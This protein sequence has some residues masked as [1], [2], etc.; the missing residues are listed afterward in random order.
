MSTH[1]L[2]QIRAA[3]RQL[4]PGSVREAAERPVTI[5][6]FA[7][8]DEA[9]AW[10]EELFAPSSL[11]VEERRRALAN[12]FRATEPG[13]PERF[14]IEVCEEGLHLSDGAV[15]FVADA[16]ERTVEWIVR[17]HKDLRL[18]LAR[19]FR[20][21]RDPVAESLIFETAR[22]NAL[23]ALVAVAPRLVPG[24]AALMWP[25]GEELLSETAFMTINEIR[26]AFL[27]AATYGRPVG[28]L[29]QK[30]EIGLIVA[31]AFLWREMAR[32]GAARSGAVL[33]LTATSGIAYAGTYAIGT[34]LRRYYA[35]GRKLEESGAAT[36]LEETF[37]H[38][39]NLARSLV[40]EKGATARVGAASG[41]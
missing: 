7:A 1:I 15:P 10:M 40:G 6:L 19:Q 8:S 23:F 36:A 5:G 29:E 21:F 38:G 14:D 25:E 32:R 13:S 30:V 39:V 2:R 9:C 12:V 41:K 16:P 27:L 4:D 24:L 22:E 34:A 26:L 35:A 37:R 3:V 11:P 28:Y 31:S 33:G 17:R 20:R 18:A